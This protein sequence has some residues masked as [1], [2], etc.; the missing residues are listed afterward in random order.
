[1]KDACDQQNIK[2][3]FVSGQDNLVMIVAFED[4]ADAII[5]FVLFLFS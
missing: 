2:F 4:D 3:S 5:L 1:M